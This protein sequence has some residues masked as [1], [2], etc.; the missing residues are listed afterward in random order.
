MAAFRE[1][2]T[3][4]DARLNCGAQDGDRETVTDDK[5]PVRILFIHP[6]VYALGGGEQVC[7][8]MIAAAQRLGMVTLIHCGGALDC[9]LIW[10]WFHVALDPERVRFMTA[11]SLGSLLGR[12]RRK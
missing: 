1:I 9:E 7:V 5:R 4:G 10:K 8:K 11:G 2:Q 12:T 3:S 6:D